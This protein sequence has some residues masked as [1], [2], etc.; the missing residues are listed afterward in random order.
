MDNIDIMQRKRQ[1]YINEIILSL[2]EIKEDLTIDLDN[3]TILGGRVLNIF[4][5]EHKLAIQ[6][7]DNYFGSSIFK[8]ALY[9]QENTIKCGKKR[10]RLIHIFEYEWINPDLRQK[11]LV[12]LRSII[13]PTTNRVEYARKLEV[14]PISKIL[15]HDFID[16]YHIQSY[17]DSSIN[18]GLYK[19]SELL[20]VITFGR[21]R[22]TRSRN[23]SD[24]TYELIRL[25]YKSEVAVVGGSAKLFKQFII[26]YSPSVI[27]SYCDISKFYGAVYPR[28]GFK[29]DENGLTRPNYVWVN[30]TNG[31]VLKRYQTMKHKLIVKGYGTEEQTETDIM[32]SIGYS[33]IYDCGNFRFVWNA[34]DN[35]F[36]QV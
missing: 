32:K 35:E 36:N 26:D 4:L 19:S 5:P 8:T 33:Q 22:F 2:R 29:L 9:N 31:D 1:L 7:N 20:G 25:S 27:L 13:S 16:K 14:L 12:L 30:T 3:T 21:P 6:F 28:L 23:K 24:G 10:I 11:I 15:A 18:Y 17:T 34:P